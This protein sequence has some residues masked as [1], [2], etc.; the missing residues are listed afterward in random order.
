M[1]KAFID[2]DRTLEMFEEL[3][4]D[5]E[6]KIV[7]EDIE[8]GRDVGARDDSDGETMV[9][10]ET[11]YVNTSTKLARERKIKSFKK[12]MKQNSDVLKKRIVEKLARDMA[13]KD[14]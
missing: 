2:T 11:D 10:M 7:T 12:I 13:P 1:N 9:H 8:S 3:S 4:F 6:V 14:K 5:S